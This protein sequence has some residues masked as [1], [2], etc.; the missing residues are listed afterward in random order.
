[1]WD[2]V[3]E[4]VF[5]SQAWG[6][7]PAEELIRFV[8]RNYYK[9]LDR[10]RVR[11]LEIGC[12]PGAN[13]W[14]LA[15]EGFGFVGVDGSASAIRQAAERLDAECPGWRERGELH[16]GD[17]GRLPFPDHSFDAVID[18][19]AVCCNDFDASV[20]I[21]A[22]AR[23]VLKDDGRM[24]VRTFATGCWGDGTG[25][26]IGH[27]AWHCAEGPLEGKGLARFTSLE[28]IP[29]LMEGFDNIATELL[30]WS[31]NERRHVIKEWII[32]AGNPA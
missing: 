25:E 2:P 16:Q 4:K 27:N 21:Y 9:A 22:E 7:Y 23:R 29:L 12:G 11:F 26:K 28:E 5:S 1:M 15:R 18:N 14:Y 19:E 31:L 13:L 8:A 6:K 10:S 3:W 24:F 30:T 17:I 20:G 32:T